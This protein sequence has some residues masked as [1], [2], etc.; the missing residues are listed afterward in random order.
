MKIVK[1]FK[2]L[3][4][5]GKTTAAKALQAA[6]PG[7]WKRI[8]RDDLRAMVDNGAYS[9][10]NEAEIRALKEYLLRTYLEAGHDVIVD[11]THI[12][13]AARKLVHDVAR[14][15]GDVKV[16]EEWID[17]SLDECIERN[18]K[19]AHSVPKKVIKDMQR[20]I[21]QFPGWSD[22]TTYYPAH[23]P[24]V[25]DT[26]KPSAI[27]CDLDGTLALFE[28]HRGPYDASKCADDK[29]CAEVRTVLDDFY[30]CLADRRQGQDDKIIFVSGREEKYREPTV[31]FLQKYNYWPYQYALFMRATGDTRPDDI[32][33]RELFDQHIKDKYYVEFVIDDRP[34][35]VRMWRKL[36]LF[37]FQ[38]NDKEF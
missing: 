2:G 14:Q 28:H 32:V 21:N 13:A 30:D 27:I 22:S 15:V 8:N 38:V 26:S 17:C 36:G 25:Q 16:E 37:V 6:Q 9:K 35:V 5:S 29:V 33:K 4:A 3:P 11:D 7:R 10:D 1:M 31:T 12:E 18:A 19:R 23:T 20:R 34:R 24:V